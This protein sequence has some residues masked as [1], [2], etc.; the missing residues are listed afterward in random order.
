MYCLLE[1]VCFSLQVSV[2]RLFLYIFGLHATLSSFMSTRQ[3]IFVRDTLGL[4]LGKCCKVRHCVTKPY[5][6]KQF[7][8]RPRS[9]YQYSSVA[10]RLSGKNCKFFKFLLSSN[11]QQRL[12]YNENNTKYRSLTRKPRSHVRILI[13]RTWPI[14]KLGYILQSEI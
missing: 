14:K 2:S 9:I 4:V 13:Y 11:S 5:S 1:T 12:R 8:N 6:Y 7:Q 3:G 10:P